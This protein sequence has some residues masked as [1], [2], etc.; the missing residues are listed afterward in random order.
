MRN[1]LGMSIAMA[2]RFI[3]SLKFCRTLPRSLKKLS[4]QAAS[5]ID[6]VREVEVKNALR[7][8]IDVASG[9]NLVSSGSLQVIPLDFVRSN[10]YIAGLHRYMW[11][12]LCSRL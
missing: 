4:T 3:D 11:L 8:V 5:Q 2:G 9:K 6:L 10:Y 7:K 12:K 1:L